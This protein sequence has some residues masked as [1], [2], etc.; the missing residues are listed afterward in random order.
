MYHFKH[1]QK[2][3][4]YL[5]PQR[6]ALFTSACTNLKESSDMLHKAGKLAAESWDEADTAQCP[7]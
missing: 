3:S 6:G 1:C 5:F 2:F 7:G 4:V